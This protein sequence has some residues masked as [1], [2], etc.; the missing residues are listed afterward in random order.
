MSERPGSPWIRRAEVGEEIAIVLAS[1]SKARRDLLASAG[2]AFEVVPA[3]I[4]EAAV[5]NEIPMHNGLP[6]LDPRRIATVLACEKAV[7]VSV[8][9]PAALVIGA[10]Q[11]LAVKAQILSKAKSIDEARDHLQR[12][13]GQP[14]ELHSAVALAERGSVVWRNVQA[15]RLTMR[16]FSEAFLSEY[17]AREGNEVCSSVGAYKIE[18]RGIQLFDKIEGDHSTILGLPLLPLLEELRRR[19]VLSA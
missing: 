7:A 17:L 1:G 2:L 9:H 19:G 4:D 14:H 15:A 5:V 12:L 13:R 18:G 11:V 10:D 16:K 3:A 8:K 6:P